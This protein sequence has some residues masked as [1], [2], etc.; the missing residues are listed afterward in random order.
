MLQFLG[1]F[2]FVTAAIYKGMTEYVFD[3]NFEIFEPSS[4][5][6]VLCALN[7]ADSIHVALK[8]LAKQNVVAKFPDRF[9]FLLV[10]SNSE[11]DTAS[12]AEGYGWKVVQAPRGKLKS[13][14]LGNRIAQGKVIVSVDADSEYPPNW[15]NLMLRHFNDPNIVAVESPRLHPPPE[16]LAW[17][18]IST[19][20]YFLDSLG[21][22]PK[23]CG[24]GSAF[25]RQAYFDSGG[26]KLEMDSAGMLT[27]LWKEEE[28]YFPWRLTQFGR[29]ISDFH[30]PHLTSARR[31]R[32]IFD[33]RQTGGR[34][35]FV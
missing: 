34:I 33:K 16:G 35:S 17:T 15:L 22:A 7:E 24:S 6:V 26:F 30:A 25:R 4:T 12:I 31:L 13:R 20:F 14:D 18:A 1:P 3:W 27:G 9:E 21:V 23:L 2:A 29:V 8:S 19:W 10:D 5:S 11:D 32:A 28:M